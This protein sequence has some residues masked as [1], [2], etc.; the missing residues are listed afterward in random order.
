MHALR[1]AAPGRLPV[2]EEE[3]LRELAD[4]LVFAHS[5]DGEVRRALM[6]A[7]LVLLSLPAGLPDR[8]VDDVADGL[9]ACAPAPALARAR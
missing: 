5:R 8:W 3:Q 4:I 7:R 9:E 1:S 6:R 2:G